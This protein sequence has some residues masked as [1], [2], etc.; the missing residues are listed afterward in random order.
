MSISL[1]TG[2][3]PNG[4]SCGRVWTCPPIFFSS[5]ERDVSLREKVDCFRN[6]ATFRF[7][8]CQFDLR[9]VALLCFEKVFSGRSSKY[10]VMVKRIRRWFTDSISL[11]F[12][13][14]VPGLALKCILSFLH[15][16]LR[17]P[18]SKIVVPRTT[19]CLDSV[20]CFRILDACLAVSRV[21]LPSLFE[22][23][24][25]DGQ[26]RNR[27]GRKK[28]IFRQRRPAP[29][30]SRNSARVL[31]CLARADKTFDEPIRGKVVEQVQRTVAKIS[32]RLEPTFR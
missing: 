4:R 19:R 24:A 18:C 32:S 17:V 26:K 16:Y 14:T 7:T 8:K 27:R 15:C 2:V 28:R 13:L 21:A 11:Q 23:W 12:M 31:A 20:Y 1:S 22:T 25:D 10:F 3:S 6:C 9:S 29:T 30:E 5:F